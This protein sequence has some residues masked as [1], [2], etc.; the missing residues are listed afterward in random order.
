MG[1]HA[2]LESSEQRLQQIILFMTQ[3]IIESNA[4]KV[5]GVVSP[6]NSSDASVS[7]IAFVLGKR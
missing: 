2:S 3:V 4:F 6:F 5:K 1:V 7:S